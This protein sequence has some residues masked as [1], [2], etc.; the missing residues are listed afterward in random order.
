MARSR[1]GGGGSGA[2]Q[3]FGARQLRSV[4]QGGAWDASA[5]FDDQGREQ[6]DDDGN[7][8]GEN[9]FPGGQ[10]VINVSPIRAAAQTS[11]ATVR[12]ISHLV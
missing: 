5:R 8:N 2:L 1:A 3:R 9:Q 4:H 12:P 11:N 6:H 7:C 10:T